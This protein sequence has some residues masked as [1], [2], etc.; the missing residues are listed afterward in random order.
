MYKSRFNSFFKVKN[1]A[2]LFRTCNSFA[3]LS[4]KLGLFHISNKL[5]KTQF[6]CLSA[7]EIST[8]RIPFLTEHMER[9][10]KRREDL[11]HKLGNFKVFKP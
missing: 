11:L 10:K 6:I 4:T 2:K 8:V 7:K 3:F 1:N 9:L 5:C